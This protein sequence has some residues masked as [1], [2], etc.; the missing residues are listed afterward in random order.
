LESG[1]KNVYMNDNELAK[2]YEG[3]F[4]LEMK[5]NEYLFIRDIDENVI[6]KKKCNSEGEITHL[7]H[8]PI[9][10]KNNRFSRKAIVPLNDEQFALFDLLQNRQITVKQ[11]TGVAGSGKN[12]CAFA[13]AMEAIDKGEYN[14]VVLIRNN[15]GVK[16]TCELGALPAGINEKLLPF[17]MPAADLL[18]STSELFKLIENEQV[19]LVHLGFV[20]GR[21]F[22]NSIIIVDESENLTAEHASLLVSRVGK[23]SVIMFLGDLDQVDKPIFTKNSGLERLNER[24]VGHPLYGCVHLIKTE[25]SETAALANLMR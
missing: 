8:K 1:I 5:L 14:K 21:S 13:Y 22:E 24:L 17:A 6:D 2:F 3:K 15:I 18:G 9:G 25:R 4:P 23:G 10:S 16:D 7:K 20:R 19:E 12:Y 11:I